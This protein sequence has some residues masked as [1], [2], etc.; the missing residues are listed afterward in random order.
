MEEHR[1]QPITEIVNE[2]TGLAIALYN[3]CTDCGKDFELPELAN[4]EEN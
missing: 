4:F 3:H 1:L 2:E